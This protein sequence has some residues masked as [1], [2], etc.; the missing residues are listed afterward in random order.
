MKT[1]LERAGAAVD[2]SRWFWEFL[3]EENVNQARLFVQLVPQPSQTALRR[4]ITAVEDLG[5]SPH[6]FTLRP[7]KGHLVDENDLAERRKDTPVLDAGVPKFLSAILKAMLG[8]PERYRV[9]E[10]R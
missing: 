2:G 1:I 10:R 5:L 6:R 8:R 3:N 9:W 7:F 4:E